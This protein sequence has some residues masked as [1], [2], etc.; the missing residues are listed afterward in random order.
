MTRDVRGRQEEG[1]ESITCNVTCRLEGRQG[2]TRDVRS[3][4]EERTGRV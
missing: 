4:Q 2:V 3:R 1:R